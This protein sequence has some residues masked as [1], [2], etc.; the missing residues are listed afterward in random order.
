MKIQETINNLFKHL[1]IYPLIICG[2]FIVVLNFLIFN[3]LHYKNANFELPFIA[4]IIS[5]IC[6]ILLGLSVVTEI[7]CSIFNY[8]IKNE[9]IIN[10][11]FV[12][13]FGIIG[14]LTTLIAVL[15]GFVKFICGSE[16][17]NTLLFYQMFFVF[18]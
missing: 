7:V 10:N 9:F 16:Y 17:I 18:I 2:W 11:K 14:I 3:N 5:S 13:V 15:I 6:I 1:S 4:L 12:K 8:E